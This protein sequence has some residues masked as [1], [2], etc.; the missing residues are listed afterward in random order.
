MTDL[1][2]VDTAIDSVGAAGEAALDT[3]VGG[4]AIA[5]DAATRP[6]RSAG[7]ARRRGGAVNEAL[8]DA[9]EELVDEVTGLPE[10]VLVGYLRLLR[11]QGRRDDVLG[12]VS[13]GVLGTVHDQARGAARFFARLERETDVDRHGKRRTA[14]RSST[15]TRSTRGRSTTATRTRGRTAGGTTRRGTTGRRTAATRARR[16]A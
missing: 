9:G 10:R 5:L 7:R 6:R 16:T 12:I 15:T 2:I 4:A 11:R 3:V 1:S 13:R 14:R 8:L